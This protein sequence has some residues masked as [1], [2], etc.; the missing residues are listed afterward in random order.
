MGP[1]IPAK[2]QSLQTKTV[3]TAP[4]LLDLG[5]AYKPRAVPVPLAARENA[6]E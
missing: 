3:G 5:P 1:L 6:T 4:K 2:D